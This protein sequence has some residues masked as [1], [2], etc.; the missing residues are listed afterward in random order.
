MERLRLVRFAA[1]AVA[2][3]ALAAGLAGA[4]DG[5]AQGPITLSIA[6]VSGDLS[7]VRTI[8]ENYQKANPQEIRAVNFRLCHRS[9]MVAMRSFA[10]SSGTIL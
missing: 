2:L 7:S 10:G 8:I 1:V 3:L 6:D 4:R 9:M 5:A